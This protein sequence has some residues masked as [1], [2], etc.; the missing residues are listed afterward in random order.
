VVTEAFF[1]K[2]RELE[3]Q[4]AG[5]YEQLRRYYRVDPARW[6][7]VSGYSPTYGARTCA[8]GL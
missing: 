1:E 8:V 2:P 7:I 4:H 6:E 5:L 3:M